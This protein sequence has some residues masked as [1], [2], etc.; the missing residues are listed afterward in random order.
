MKQDLLENALSALSDRHIAE[1]AGYQKKRALPRWLPYAAACLLLAA[2]LAGIKA[3]L[4]ALP[5]AQ[6]GSPQKEEEKNRPF[7]SG[8]AVYPREDIPSSPKEGGVYLPPPC[9]DLAAPKSGM[10]ADML[11][12]FIWEGRTYVGH[13]DFCPAALAGE[14]MGTAT[15]LIDEWTPSDGYV[16]LAGS[17]N[18]DFYQVK[19]YDPA[20]VLCMPFGQDRYELMVCSGGITLHTG[21]DLYEALLRLPGR[22]ESAALETRE[23]WCYGRD[24]KASLPADERLDDFVRAMCDSEVR[25]TDELRFPDG[26]YF[27][28]YDN[29]ELYHLYLTLEDGFTVHL[30]LLE[31]G[32]VLYQGL[33]DVYVTVPEEV[34][35]ALCEAASAP[36]R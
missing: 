2:G 7:L 10:A 33:T 23:S 17:I 4:P 30:R 13:N 34:F 18:G 3:R 12:F 26:V 22:I 9:F 19:G 35:T 5:S 8:P 32:V 11:A 31:G 1:A 20:F 24:R 36:Q 27:N 16:E 29:T 15:G 21:A 6:V 25:L 14:K 28:I